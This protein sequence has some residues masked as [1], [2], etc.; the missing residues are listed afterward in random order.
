MNYSLPD[1]KRDALIG[2]IES[3]LNDDKLS[4][5]QVA[6]IVGSSQELQGTIEVDELAH[7][8]EAGAVLD[9]VIERWGQH[10]GKLVLR[11]IFGRHDG[12]D[13]NGQPIRQLT[14]RLTLTRTRS[15]ERSPSRGAD[16]GVEALSSSLGGA[17][18]TLQRQVSA[19][20]DQQANMLASM[21]DRTDNAN[22]SRVQ[23]ITTYQRTIMELSTELAEE[24]ILRA[25]SESQ[26]A[27]PPEILVTLV[28]TL[29]PAVG[30]ALTALAV[31][32]GAP[33]AS[34][35]ISS[36]AEAVGVAVDLGEAAP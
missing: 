27:V 34:T 21:L 17:L 18:D 33:V 24:K 10:G 36:A 14:R 32:L 13:L 29:A 16:S 28:Q 3:W 2:A 23:E 7:L 35:T 15:G 9:E 22:L 8:A 30:E 4:E 1:S 6:R 12:G 11:A 19:Q 20:G 5:L 25:I 26:P 31:R